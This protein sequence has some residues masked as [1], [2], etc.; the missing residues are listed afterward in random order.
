MQTVHAQ[1][2]RHARKHCSCINCGDTHTDID[3]YCQE[4]EVVRIKN[5]LDPVAAEHGGAEEE[6]AAATGY[7]DVGLNLR[8]TSAESRERGVDG[9]VAEVSCA[10]PSHSVI[11]S[12]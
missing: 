9:H 6:A 7:R 1:C 3:L 8:V 4:V 10:R 5:R 2:L 11:L 12:V